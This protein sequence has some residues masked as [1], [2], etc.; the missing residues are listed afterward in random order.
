MPGTSSGGQT[1]YTQPSSQYVPPSP[2]GS[3]YAPPTTS[4]GSQYVNPR[5][6]VVEVAPAPTPATPLSSGGAFAALKRAVGGVV[7]GVKNAFSGVD[8]S[9]LTGS[10]L[11]GFNQATQST[12]SV[13]PQVASSTPSVQGGTVATQDTGQLSAKAGDVKNQYQVI[14]QDK[15]SDSTT[16]QNNLSQTKALEDQQKQGQIADIKAKI[17]ALTAQRD[18]MIA[19]GEQAPPV[20]PSQ[21]DQFGLDTPYAPQEQP[22]ISQV[23]AQL[24]ALEAELASAMGDSPEYTAAN[25]ALN[26]KIAEEA[27]IKAR[28]QQG[29]TNIGEQ[30]I[31]YSFISG[32]QAALERRGQADLAN[33]YSAQIPLQQR[34][35]TEQAKKQS[36]IDVVKNKY[37]F[38]GDER[39]RLVDTYKTNYQ[40][41]N[42]LA[43]QEQEQ[44]RKLQL[45]AG[46]PKSSSSTTSSSKTLYDGD[47]ILSGIQKDLIADI[48]N[49]GSIANLY[50][51]YPEVDRLYVEQ[52][53]NR[54]SPTKSSTIGA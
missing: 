27:A 13:S 10:A 33:V 16:L 12:S 28:I 3:G 1:D 54:I 40:R 41:S 6:G 39:D 2:S 29:Q 42:Q 53:F 21:L 34:L 48:Q 5:T 43:D 18:Q 11:T 25:E 51:A 20:D 38:L 14:T 19:A 22:A 24:Q 26:A 8:S 45:E 35:A 23:S 9:A 50:R 44:Q 15:T 52:L 37:G 4:S 47:T 36:A 30:P 17:Q 31:A 7:S 49:G 46:K 32:Q